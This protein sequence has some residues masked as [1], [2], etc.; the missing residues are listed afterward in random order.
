MAWRFCLASLAAMILA[1]QLGCCGGCWPCG[2]NW[3]GSQCG[4][5]YWHEWFS[6]PPDCC[7]PCTHSGAFC[8]PNNRFLR[9]GVFAAHGGAVGPY[10]DQG[11]TNG[12]NMRAAPAGE[13][14]RQSAPGP[15]E[16]RPP[17][18]SGPMTDRFPSDDEFRTSEELPPAESS[19]DSGYRYDDGRRVAYDEQ[20]DSPR[21]SRKLGRPSYP[22]RRYAR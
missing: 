12:D 7:D 11:E 18:G 10:Y 5:V 16:A 1:A 13:P 15:T 6:L 3:C 22:A 17:V 19:S 2:K 9:R 8:G 21:P 20:V 14:M 4:E